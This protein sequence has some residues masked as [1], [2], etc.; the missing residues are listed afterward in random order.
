MGHFPLTLCSLLC[1]YSYTLYIQ[2][3]LIVAMSFTLFTKLPTELQVMIWKLAIEAPRVHLLPPRYQNYHRTCFTRDAVKPSPD[4]NHSICLCPKHTEH[5]DY[6][7]F[8]PW[9]CDHWDCEYGVWDC[10][11][12]LCNGTHTCDH[13]QS[14]AT[15][16]KYY[17]SAGSIRQV[18]R[19][20]RNL[21]SEFSVLELLESSNGFSTTFIQFNPACDVIYCKDTD[22]S[23]IYTVYGPGLPFLAVDTTSSICREQGAIKYRLQAL[24]LM[25]HVK[26][27]LLIIIT[28]SISLFDENKERT[29]QHCFKGVAEVLEQRKVIGVSIPMVWTMTRRDLEH[30]TWFKVLTVLEGKLRTLRKQEEYFTK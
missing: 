4:C 14:F 25:T 29:L 16:R 18:C 11:S 13:S 28:D 10:E 8:R 6:F 27:K 21:T 20:S 3:L 5:I 9:I 23:S 17:S 1:L 24:H 7:N 12:D 2:V 30:V 22:I 15:I 26:P 19:I